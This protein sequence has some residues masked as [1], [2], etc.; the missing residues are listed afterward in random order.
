MPDFPLPVAA[1]VPLS[2]V[3][4][5]L[6]GEVGQATLDWVAAAGARSTADL[7]QHVAAVTAALAGHEHIDAR[8]ARSAGITAAS[9]RR[10]GSVTSTEAGARAGS[11][12]PGETS[13]PALM[14]V[15]G[16]GPGLPALSCPDVPFVA[17]A[18]AAE[19]MP[20]LR[21]LLHYACGFIETIVGADWW[22]ADSCCEEP[23]WESMRLAAVCYLV[24]RAEAA[25]EL[26]PDLRPTA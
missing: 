12:V 20:P 15:G 14:A 22:P 26:H 24:G 8:A 11:G 9:E 6:A 17:D 19:H 23:D 7:D 10:H 21:L 2:T 5:R 25:A 18:L 4:L 3:S 13:T 1:P 16:S